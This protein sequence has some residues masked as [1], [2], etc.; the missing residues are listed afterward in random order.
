MKN[1]GFGN[2][3]INSTLQQNTIKTPHINQNTTLINFLSKIV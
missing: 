1:K 2:N 3:Y